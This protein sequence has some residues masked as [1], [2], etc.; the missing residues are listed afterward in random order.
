MSMKVAVQM[1]VGW[2]LCASLVFGHSPAHQEAE[3]AVR[4]DSGGQQVIVTGC[5]KRSQD[6]YLLTS[7]TGEVYRLDPN[8]VSL[9]HFAKKGVRVVGT[10]SGSNLPPG[11]GPRAGGSSAPILKVVNV[12]KIASKCPKDEA[13]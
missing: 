11:P 10:I 12:N 5:L 13:R 4:Q 9:H 1:I 7:S 8:G 3:D 2:L 6:D